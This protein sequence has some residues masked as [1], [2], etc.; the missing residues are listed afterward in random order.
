MGTS[1]IRMDPTA[2]EVSVPDVALHVVMANG[3]ELSVPLVWFPR[4]L[5]ATPAQRSHWRFI[6]RGAGIHWPD[7]EE[8]ASMESLP[9]LH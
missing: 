1:A 5:N 6:G 7:V 8:D 4:L 3:R 9:R 2:V